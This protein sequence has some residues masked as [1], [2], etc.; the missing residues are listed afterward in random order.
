MARKGAFTDDALGDIDDLLPPAPPRPVAASRPPVAQAPA[1]AVVET[2]APIADIAETETVPVKPAPRKTTRAAAAAGDTVAKR[3]KPAVS[4]RATNSTPEAHVASLAAEALRQLTHAEKQQR[5]QGR[6]YGAVVL[7]A[8]E[9]HMDEIKRHFDPAANAKPAGR[10]FARVDHSRP[11]RRRHAEPPVKIPLA[12]I[13]A[14][15][16]AQLDELV[17]EWHAG[18]RSALVDKALQLYLAEDIARLAGEEEGD[19]DAST[20][21]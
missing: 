21:N 8:I 5:G 4:R 15:D 17:V 3:T 14:A 12:G 9:Q 20:E 7:D 16:L 6:S 19:E 10:L 13:I 11:R 1:A 2:H 18:S